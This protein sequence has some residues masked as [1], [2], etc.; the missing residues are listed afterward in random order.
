MLA[1]RVLFI[2]FTPDT[3]A[4]TGANN[5]ADNRTCTPVLF[6]DNGPDYRTAHT[7]D[8]SA[9][10]AI[11]PTAFL[12]CFLSGFGSFRFARRGI[13]RRAAASSLCRRVCGSSGRTVGRCGLFSGRCR[14][15][16]RLCWLCLFMH[17]CGFLHY[18]FA[19]HFHGFWRCCFYRLCLRLLLLHGSVQFVLR[20]PLLKLRQPG[21]VHRL[22][23]RRQS[24]YFS[25]LRIAV[26]GGYQK[27][28]GKKRY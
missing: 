17:R 14:C 20:L 11:A 26:A 28:E 24:F 2:F 19:N 22:L 3:V 21:G 10:G 7:T 27:G 1:G 8:G 4:Y 5:A 18:P 9:F 15:G 25:G 16:C 23:C 13:L 12:C 6:V